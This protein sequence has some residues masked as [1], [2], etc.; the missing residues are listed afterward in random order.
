MQEVFYN[1]TVSVYRT[2]G[3]ETCGKA[4]DNQI[5]ALATADYGVLTSAFRPC[6]PI[7]SE[8]DVERLLFYVKGAFATLAMLDYPYDQ[9]FVTDMP[10][11]PVQVA[12]A[13]LQNHTNGQSGESDFTGLNDA[14]NVF[15]NYS[16]TSQCHNIS[17]EMVGSKSTGSGATFM[18]KALMQQA[19]LQRQT[20]DV[21]SSKSTGD[22]SPGSLGSIYDTWNYQVGTLCT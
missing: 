21:T 4:I 22:P 20:A 8:A 14:M 5:R 18:S 3:S 11:N 13:R 10:A 15:V 2:Y 9:Q 7:Q 1:A 19:R 12:C 17:M 6:S 16:G